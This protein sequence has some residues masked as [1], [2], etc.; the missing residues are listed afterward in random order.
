MIEPEKLA[1]FVNQSGF[2][3]QIGI[4]SLVNRFHLKVI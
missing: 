1:D 4:G 3:L 2:P